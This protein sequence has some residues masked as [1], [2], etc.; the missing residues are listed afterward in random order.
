MGCRRYGRYD[1]ILSG[2]RKE[3]TSNTGILKTKQFQITV[4][5]SQSES[6]QAGDLILTV[7]LI[8]RDFGKI[9]EKKYTKWF[10]YDRIEQTLVIRHRQPGDRI[11]LFDGGGS[12]KL[13]DYLIDRKIPA[14]RTGSAVASGRRVRHPVDHRRPNQRSV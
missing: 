8:S 11:C 12:K 7:S 10:D 2:T 1:G 4:Q 3:K 6:F 5:S 13:K 14:G 9:Q